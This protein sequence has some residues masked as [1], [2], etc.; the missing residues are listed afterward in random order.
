MHLG[1]F[2][3]VWANWEKLLQSLRLGRSA[4]LLPAQNF[5]VTLNDNFASP[6]LSLSSQSSSPARPL[7]QGSSHRTGRTIHSFIGLFNE[8]LWNSY[9]APSIGFNA[10]HFREKPALGPGLT[11]LVSH[12]EDSDKLLRGRCWET[13]AGSRKE[14]ASS[15]CPDAGSQ[16]PLLICG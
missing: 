2:K 5:A 4:S 14:E 6:S 13:S 10:G 3:R 9:R 1:G 16:L 8:P 11:W 7:V 15:P 12:R